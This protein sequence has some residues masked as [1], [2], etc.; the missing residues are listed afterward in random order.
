MTKSD[1][2]AAAR[3]HEPNERPTE[4]RRTISGTQRRVVPPPEIETREFTREELAPLVARS[5]AEDLRAERPTLVGAPPAAAPTPPAATPTPP[6]ARAP[7]AV[8]DSPLA[9]APLPRAAAPS[10]P[11]WLI[12][13]TVLVCLAS[14]PAVRLATEYA[15]ALL[16]RH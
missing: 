14:A 4:P 2:G 3:E 10:T 13:V 8:A 7:A 15:H 5:R 11:V 6:A 9:P 16:V 1:R 12:V